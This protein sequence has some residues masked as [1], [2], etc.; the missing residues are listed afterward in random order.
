[1]RC[2]TRLALV[3]SAL[4]AALL[5]HAFMNVSLSDGERHKALER[6]VH[7]MGDESTPK[8]S[9]DNRV[10]TVA[11]V[12]TQAEG[13]KLTNVSHP[14]NIFKEEGHPKI[15]RHQ[16]NTDDGL[17]HKTGNNDKIPHRLNTDDKLVRE[18]TKNDD[19]PPALADQSA[20]GENIADE[21]HVLYQELRSDP[22][23]VS[24]EVMLA[25]KFTFIRIAMCGSQSLINPMATVAKKNVPS[26]T[27]TMVPESITKRRGEGYAFN[28]KLIFEY[29]YRYPIPY[30]SIGGHRFINFRRYG[31]F[32]PISLTVFA[33]PVERFTKLFY[34]I[35]KVYMRQKRWGMKAKSNIQLRPEARNTTLARCAMLLDKNRLDSRLS[36]I[37]QR[38]YCGFELSS[39]A[40]VM[41]GEDKRCS[42]HDATNYTLQEALKNLEDFLVVGFADD[43]ETTV[44]VME[45]LL[46]FYLTGYQQEFLD[47]IE[48]ETKRIHSLEVTNM[49]RRVLETD[50]VLYDAAKDRFE[51]LKQELKIG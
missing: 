35:R 45:R 51:K 16:R 10:K 21:L 9:E 3:G 13:V 44:R 11:N 18:A 24:K 8:H 19:N 26:L 4:V 34:L 42:Q 23:T 38:K 17:E 33:D 6:Q 31:D 12:E 50:Y 30:L 5:I 43:M 39:L 27:L 15:P 2:I 32:Q 48:K 41:C 22:A 7:R 20:S 25:Q 1:M 47:Q 29:L 40:R 49:L 14:L 36:Q 28:E 46:P 37:I